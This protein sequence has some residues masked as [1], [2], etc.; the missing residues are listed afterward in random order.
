MAADGTRAASP[1]RGSALPD[2]L[3][4]RLE[5]AYVSVPVQMPRLPQLIEDSGVLWQRATHPHLSVLTPDRIVAR[6]LEAGRASADA[7]ARLERASELARGWPIRI[8]RY[9]EIRVARRDERR[10]VIALAVV[11]GVDA[12][13]ARLP[14]ILGVVVRPPP[15]HVTLYTAPGGKGI[16]IV[17][18]TDLHR[19]TVPAS[20]R[21]AALIA[22]SL[23]GT[24]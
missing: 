6:V 16:G 5:A 20:G 7:V 24:T 19:F 10:S 4:T 12:L 13:Y 9:T 11:V 21:L 23:T 1:P 8:V 3:V 18:E 17:D 2:T 14:D 22:S 15:A